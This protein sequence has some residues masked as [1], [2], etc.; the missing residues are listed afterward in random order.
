V[1][2]LA[3]GLVAEGLAPS[4]AVAASGAVGLFAVV[5]PLLAFRRTRGHVAPA[6]AGAG[7]S[8]A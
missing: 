3:A 1:G 4:G 6:A 8:V 5:L 2:V 7:S